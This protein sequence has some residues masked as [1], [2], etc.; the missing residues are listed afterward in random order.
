MQMIM[1]IED[2]SPQCVAGYD[3][4]IDVRSPAEFGADHIPGATNL[5]VLD[6]EERARVGTI[7][8]QTS[9]FQARRLGAALVSKNIAH[10][11]ETALA[12]KPADFRPLIYCWRG[13]M[14]SNAM[15]TVAC[16][17]GWRAGVVKDGYKRWRKLVVRGLHDIAAPLNIVLLDGQTGTAKTAILSALAAT[18]TQTIDLEDL[19]NHRGSVFGAH[20]RT[21]QP[22]QKLF[23]SKLWDQLRRLDLGRPIIIEAESN[24]I[25]KRT[26]PPRLIKAM[27]LAP[28]IEI[29]APLAARARYLVETYPDIV[30]S[31]DRLKTAID[32]LRPFHAKAEIE[33]WLKLA[34]AGE[35]TALAEALA[36]HHYDPRY[37]RHRKHH[38]RP[39][40]ARI[41]L[42]DLGRRDI[43]RA[44]G[45]IRNIVENLANPT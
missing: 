14:R 45:E 22:G 2:L 20:A 41:A 38:N 11:L 7:Y 18:G 4:V 19:A 23:E 42:P 1:Q 33:N 5:Y 3:A 34:A 31:A 6:N 21:G 37:S 40:I 16:A 26:L 32:G 30:A 15:A 9:R 8:V 35:M 27:R 24:M 43:A 28:R 10:H 29:C 17:I 13:G 12:D 36:K 25:G 39:A 44:A